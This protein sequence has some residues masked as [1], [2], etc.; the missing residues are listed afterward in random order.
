MASLSISSTISSLSPSLV[1]CPPIARTSSRPLHLPIPP[2]VAFSSHIYHHRNPRGLAVV[3]RA[4]PNTSSYV[5]AVVFPLS[6]LAVT[7]FTSIKIADKLDKDF[8]EDLTINQAIRDA[9]EDDGGI[10]ADDD[11]IS[12]ED[13]VQEPVLPRTRN[14]PKR[15]V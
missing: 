4:G 2:G 14:R 8:L 15:E 6:L 3:T 7:I 13:I 12:L 1:L 9:D 5:F 10:D 11:E